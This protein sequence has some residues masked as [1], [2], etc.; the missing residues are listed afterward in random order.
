MTKDW[1]SPSEITFQREEIIWI[2]QNLDSL[3]AGIRPPEHKETGYPGK[4]RGG[5]SKRAYFEDPCMIAAEVSR[6]LKLTKTD[7]KL[8]KAQVQSG[9]TNYEDLEP[10]AQMALNYIALWDF[11]KRPRYSFWKRDRK[12]Y[13]QKS[14]KNVGKQNG[15]GNHK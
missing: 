10:E 3:S 4:K 9:I 11:R 12:Y 13:R 15:R 8:L 7:G 5:I 2:L 6:R 14:Y 1:Y